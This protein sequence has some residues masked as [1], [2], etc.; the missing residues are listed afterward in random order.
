MAPFSVFPREA[1]R[2]TDSQQFVRRGNRSSTS[3]PTQEQEGRTIRSRRTSA[4]K[5]ATIWAVDTD[6]KR[7]A[8]VAYCASRLHQVCAI[9]DIA[10]LKQNRRTVCQLD[11]PTLLI[12]VELSKLPRLTIQLWPPSQPNNFNYISRFKGRGTIFGCLVRASAPPPRARIQSPTSRPCT[13]AGPLCP[14]RPLPRRASAQPPGARFQTHTSKTWH[15]HGLRYP[16]RPRLAEQPHH[17]QV[18]VS[19]RQD[20]GGGTIMV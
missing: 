5:C 17:L 7:V 4:P 16:C 13:L 9:P 18:P 8:Y 14:C 3:G 2:T 12:R 15:H 20:Q 19:R 6:L 10:T 11:G 1:D